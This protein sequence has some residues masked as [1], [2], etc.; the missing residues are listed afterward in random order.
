[1]KVS[2]VRGHLIE[3]N[4]PKVYKSWSKHNPRIFFKDVDCIV[5]P[6]EDMEELMENLRMLARGVQLLVL[7]LDCDREGVVG[8]V[9]RKLLPLR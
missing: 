5:Q 8:R 3:Y 4:F 9:F 2:S 1:M 7:W 6:G